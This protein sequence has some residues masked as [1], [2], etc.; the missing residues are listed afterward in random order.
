[1]EPTSVVTPGLFGSAQGLDMGPFPQ[2]CSGTLPVAIALIPINLGIG[3][4]PAYTINCLP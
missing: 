3:R 4:G 2:A 1:M